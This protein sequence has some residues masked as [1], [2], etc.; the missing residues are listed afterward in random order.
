MAGKTV[1][2]EGNPFWSLDNV[3]SDG[4][5]CRNRINFQFPRKENQ[6]VTDAVTCCAREWKQDRFSFNQCHSRSNFMF[7]RNV[8]GFFR[9]GLQCAGISFRIN[10][11]DSPFHFVTWQVH[12]RAT[13]RQ[14]FHFSC[15]FTRVFIAPFIIQCRRVL[16]RLNLVVGV[17]RCWEH[18]EVFFAVIMNHFSRHINFC[19]SEPGDESWSRRKIM[20]FR[21]SNGN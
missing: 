10:L 13:Q 4:I 8:I 6:K 3:V 7:A 15:L 17:A 2:C 14:H 16:F 21:G 5:S 9:S 19:L 18:M 1:T 11:E 20:K 12:R